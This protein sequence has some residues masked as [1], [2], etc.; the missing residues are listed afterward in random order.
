MA[1]IRAF[2]GASSDGSATGSSAGVGPTANQLVTD[3]YIDPA[4]TN[5]GN[6]NNNGLTP[7]TPLLSVNR[8]KQLILGARYGAPG[9]P[10]L[11]QIHA[12]SSSA[13]TDDGNFNGVFTTQSNA[14]VFII[15]VPT[16]L[17]SGVLT[18][19]TAYA[20][21]ARATVTDT[22]LSTTWTL[23]GGIGTSGAGGG[24]RFIR[25]TDLSIQ[26]DL[27]LD[28]EPTLATRTA[29]IGLPTNTSETSTAA[30]PNVAITNF[31]VGDAYEVV[32][33][34]KWPQIFTGG[35]LM[36]V[37]CLDT[38][39]SGA[40]QT[41]TMGDRYVLCG[42]LTT[43]SRGAGPQQ[44]YKCSVL[45]NLVTGDGFFAACCTLVGFI[46]Q[47]NG[48][49]NLNTQSNVSL[50]GQMQPAHGGSLTAGNM[51]FFDCVTAAFFNLL[52][53]AKLDL[54][55][56]AIRGANNTVKFVVCNGNSQANGATAGITAVTTDPNPY[57]LNATAFAAPP[58]V[59]AVLG[60]A[61]YS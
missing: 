16:V 36:T 58:L 5:G 26:A 13:V 10:A 22:A 40:F 39:G 8:W 27:V 3:W 28:M 11:V 34:F 31:N 61:I 57:Q 2:V 46:W 18:G 19:A 45:A 38:I 7:A 15:G 32:S 37:Q 53:L 60:G 54:T 44:F 33:R 12:M 20:G 47:Q 52:R 42:I 9:F 4:G 51:W 50:N 49:C 59:D 48:S 55:G 56:G 41:Y 29:M 24:S 21:N 17:F 30:T 25:K 1:L 6:D 35:N 14:R 43:I 23:K